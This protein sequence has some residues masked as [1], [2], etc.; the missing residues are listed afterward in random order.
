MNS[1]Q[2][3]L[4]SMLLATPVVAL[5]LAIAPK[6]RVLDGLA[7]GGCVAGFVLG[8]FCVATSPRRPGRTLAA[9]LLLLGALACGI[10][11]MAL[12]WARTG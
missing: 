9:G 1:L 11:Y 12:L 6:G 7:F 4:R 5:C 3:T 8:I 10:G 2:F